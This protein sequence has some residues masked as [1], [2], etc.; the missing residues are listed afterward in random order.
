MSFAQTA[1]TSQ[2]PA[3][4]FDFTKRKRWADLLITELADAIILLL[5]GNGQVLFCG[6]AVTEILGWRDIDLIDNNFVNLVTQSDQLSWSASFEESTRTRRE[7]LAYVHLRCHNPQAVG[8]VPQQEM[9]FEIQGRPHYVPGEQT[10]RIFFAVAKPYPSRSENQLHSFLE[11][12]MQNE[13]LQQQ[14]A[15]LKARGV[16]ITSSSRAHGT[17]ALIL[18]SVYSPTS[19][20][21][22]MSG[23]QHQ[24][25]MGSSQGRGMADYGNP[26]MT[27]M[28]Q[29]GYEELLPSPIGSVF[30]DGSHMY[31]SHG[32]ASHG[33]PL[34][35][36]E[37]EVEDSSRKKKLKKA[38]SSE[39]YVCINCGR[40]DS[41]EWRKGPL[42]PKTLCNACGLRWAKEMRK[43]GEP[44][45]AQVGSAPVAEG[46][47]A[48][49]A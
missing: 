24:S 47:T 49:A 27:G 41:P 40:T 46:T 33:A 2:K 26:Y 32:Y 13:R 3:P 20:M 28:G 43:F 11:L 31:G 39:Q 15:E 37:E 42:G 16:N 25:M 35:Y 29:G 23:M 18:N 14:L 30:N 1:S 36:H 44:T 19:T 34:S 48:S 10:C 17:D 22:P 7:M 12:K 8:V 9:F 4:V 21:Q 5:S 6:A 38:H 45:E